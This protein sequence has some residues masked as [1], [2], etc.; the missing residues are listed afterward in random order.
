VFEAS[1]E[2]TVNDALTLGIELSSSS[3]LK[4]KHRHSSAAIHWEIIANNLSKVGWSLGY[5]S[6]PWI[7]A[8]ERSG[9]PTRTVT[10]EGVSMCVQMKS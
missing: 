2:G 1:R 9:L 7:L 4:K 10:P 3:P 5:V 8:G 6:Q